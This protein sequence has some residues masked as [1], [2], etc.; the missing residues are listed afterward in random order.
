MPNETEIL[1]RAKEYIDKLANGLDPLTNEE[2]PE[3]T[4]LN[5]AR[6]TRCFFYVSGVLQKVIDNGGEVT[7][8]VKSRVDTSHL[9]PFCL[10]DEQRA[11]IQLTERPALISSF[12]R[13]IN[14]LVPEGTLRPLKSR[15]ITDFLMQDGYLKADTYTDKNGKE[16]SCRVPTPSG[17]RAGI[18]TE[19]MNSANGMFL[20]TL[21]SAEAQRLILDNL[22][23]IIAISN[24]ELNAEIR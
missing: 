14:G 18:A 20:G 13:A 5:N 23:E 15:A 21:Y 12:T 11:R 19:W 2:L 9:P 22:D 24:G 7:R 17:E 8:V 3:D 1:A 6:L 10:S 4:V 16:K